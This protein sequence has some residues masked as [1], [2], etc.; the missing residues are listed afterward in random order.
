MD[1]GRYDRRC[2][3]YDRHDGGDADPGVV[4]FRYIFC[5]K[6]MMYV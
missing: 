1:K 4:I 3:C 2:S 5:K 6:T